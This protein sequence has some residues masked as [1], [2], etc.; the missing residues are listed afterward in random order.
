MREHLLPLSC[1]KSHANQPHFVE[2]K[3]FDELIQSLKECENYQN[4]KGLTGIM[5]GLCYFLTLL[6]ISVS[7]AAF[8]NN[9]SARDFSAMAAIFFSLLLIVSFPVTFCPPRKPEEKADF[10]SYKNDA[11]EDFRKKL[12]RS[13]QHL[14]DLTGNPQALNNLGESLLLLQKQYVTLIKKH[15]NTLMTHEALG[16]RAERLWHIPSWIF[17]R[18]DLQLQQA[19]YHKVVAHLDKL[20]VEPPM[21]Y[22]V[23]YLITNYLMPAPKFQI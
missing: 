11:W 8:C 12:R 2:T 13:P 21:S 4:R 15:V 16:K 23:T 22:D 3:D 7:L 1:L 6:G 20:F 17:D 10:F 18:P 5:L 9:G 19:A 14:K